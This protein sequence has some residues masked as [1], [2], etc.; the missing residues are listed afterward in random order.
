MS[1]SST[2][3]AVERR[4]EQERHTFHAFIHVNQLHWIHIDNTIS[5]N[6]NKKIH[7]TKPSSAARENGSLPC[8]LAHW[9]LG[10]PTSRT[11][12]RTDERD[13][14]EEMKKVD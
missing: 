4:N 6:D 11:D 1:S 13:N 5:N 10:R 2:S 3:T 8:H 14:V 9:R 7:N 12:G